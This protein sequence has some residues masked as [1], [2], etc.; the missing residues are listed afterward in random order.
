MA[1]MLAKLGLSGADE[2]FEDDRGFLKAHSEK[3]DPEKLTEDLGK[4]YDITGLPFKRFNVGIYIISSIETLIDMLREH[5]INV[6]MI[7]EITVRYANA[8]MPLIGIPEYPGNRACT[9]ISARY[10]LSVTAHLGADVEYNLEASAP[11]YRQNP[12]V[13]ALF[14]KI[15]IIGDTELDKVFPEKKSCILTIKRKDGKVFSRR[16]D[17][18][19]KGDSENPMSRADI[20]RKFSKMVVPILG[21]EKADKLMI[22]I[23]D[24]ENINDVSRLVDLMIL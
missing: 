6:D 11:A 21:R 12:S 22:L 2:I 1:A 8:V 14:N 13:I 5:E 24:I 7:E 3:P 15:N 4:R 16:N 23:N 9:H 18:P 19:F 20:E 10:I 17:K